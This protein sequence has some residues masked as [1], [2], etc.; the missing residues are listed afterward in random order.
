M[1][2][3]EW[4][5]VKGELY[6]AL[7]DKVEDQYMDMVLRYK[8]NGIKSFQEIHRWCTLQTEA[9]VM[10]RLQKLQNPERARNEGEVYQ[11]VEE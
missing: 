1:P 7:L 5:A 6:T 10:A 3:P 8:G 11:R 9:G 2:Y 4:A